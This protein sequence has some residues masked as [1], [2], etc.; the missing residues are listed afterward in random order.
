MTSN[1]DWR[2][3]LRLFLPLYA[4]HCMEQ[5]YFVYG[6]VLAGY[7]IPQQTI[8]WLLSVFFIMIMAVRPVGGWLLENF[9]VR[10]TLAFAS[11]LGFAGC[12]TLVLARSVPLLFLGRMLSGASFGIYSFGIFTYQALT[13]PEQQRGAA[14]AIV[15]SGGILPTATITPIGEWLLVTGRP[16]LYLALG[17]VICILCWYL[18]TRID[19]DSVPFRK[20]G[21]AWGTYGDLLESRPF[22]LLILTGA[23]IALVDASTVSMS[24]F[25]MERGVLVSY[26]LASGSVAGV[27]VRVGGAK[28]LNAL[29]RPV[30]LAPCGMLMSGA[31]FFVTLRPSAATFTIG[32]LLFG[33]GIGAAFPTL[34]ALVSDTLPQTLRPKGSAAALLTYDLGWFV[35]PLT[36][37]YAASLLGIGTTFRALSLLSLVSLTVLFLACWL[38]AYRKSRKG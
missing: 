23:L 37:G 15:V 7:G 2:T 25:A 29:P 17:P 6:N 12:T 4:I 20:E 33:I 31:L 10:R 24:L 26:F 5:V 8:G 19:A 38:P 16:D 13:I 28:I 36:V 35:T 18:G 34:L 9:G 3:L 1:L 11:L 21:E 30:L 14:F 27:L 22:L 32:G